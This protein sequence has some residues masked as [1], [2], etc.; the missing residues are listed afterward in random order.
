M[1]VPPRVLVV[2]GIVAFTFAVVR[3]L[4]FVPYLRSGLG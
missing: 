4:P 2:V 1:T 3:N